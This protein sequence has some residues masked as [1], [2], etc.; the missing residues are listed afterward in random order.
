MSEVKVTLNAKDEIALLDR[1]GRRCSRETLVKRALAEILKQQAENI[2]IFL[3]KEEA[4]AR[5][6]VER[7]AREEEERKL[8]PQLPEDVL[9]L[10]TRFQRSIGK[11]VDLEGREVT[12]LVVTEDE[13]L[14]A[15]GLWL[16][17]QF[18]NDDAEW[19][20]VRA[21]EL[22]PDLK[23]GLLAEFDPAIHVVKE[24]D[25]AHPTAEGQEAL[26]DA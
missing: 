1:Y 25:P 3:N 21:S 23:A 18:E 17:A 6:E 4:E 2:P 9:N 20:T 13:D 7:L 22:K 16:S 10:L 26:R 11:L 19:H 12:A 5:A 8:R 24:G 14:R 15:S